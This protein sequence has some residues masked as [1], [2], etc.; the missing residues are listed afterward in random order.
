MPA[1]Q[2]TREAFRMHSSRRP[3]TR[4]VA[5][6]L[7]AS[8]AL[9]APAAAQ[10]PGPPLWTVQPFGGMFVDAYDVGV[11]GSRTGGLLGLEVGRRIAPGVRG[12]ATVAYARV[13]DV[14]GRSPGVPY[15]VLANEWVFAAVGPAFDV[16][17]GRAT[18]SIS[19]QAGAAWRRTP[20]VGLVGRTEVDPWLARTDFSVTSVVIPGIALRLPVSHRV[21][22]GG[23]A[24]F[25]GTS[26]DEGGEVSP[27][28]SLG[29]TYTP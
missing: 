21:S 10:Q 14:G 17:V 8:L 22:L 6:A 13:H 24:S 5:F 11:D 26:L 16:A 12:V 18:A 9:A 19:L 20:V 7:G 25:Y 1:T 2:L 29:V 23:G 3:P 27:A 28:F 4:R 15:H